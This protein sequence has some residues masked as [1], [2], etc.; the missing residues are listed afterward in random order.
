MIILPWPAGPTPRRAKSTRGLIVDP[1]PQSVLHQLVSDLPGPKHETEA[2]RAAR[3]DAQM[4]EL[5]SYNPRNSAEA[6][7][8]T[9]CILLRLLAEDAH[10]DA[11][12]PNPDPAT[13]KKLQRSARQMDKLLADMQQ[14][15]ARRQAQ[16]LGKLEPATFIA[17]G[18]E[19]LL[20]P[21][22]DDPN[23]AEEA[24]SAIIVP[25]HPAPKMLQ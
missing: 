21:D 7:L 12:R 11:S 22:P 9:H 16:A 2:A 20:I 13:A 19:Q 15:L 4:A 14:T 3:F 1:L 24:F 17:L 6:M 25:L 23:V 5:L 10:R 18:L 8:A